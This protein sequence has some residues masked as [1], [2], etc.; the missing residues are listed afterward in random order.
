MKKLSFGFTLIEML[1]VVAII[2]TLSAASYSA[3]VQFNQHKDLSVTT[4]DFANTLSE[5]KSDTINQ[6]N[7]SVC[8]PN[9][10]FKGY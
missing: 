5:A 7:A 6:V 2:G 8:Q 9:N 3:F 1:V 10:T 4:A